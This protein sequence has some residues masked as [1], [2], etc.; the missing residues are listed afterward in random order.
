M[1]RFEW[2]RQHLERAGAQADLAV[3][4]HRAH[5]DHPRTGVRIADH[6][7]D[8]LAQLVAGERSKPIQERDRVHLGADGA[9]TYALDYVDR[10][11]KD[12]WK[13]ARIYGRGLLTP[14]DVHLRAAAGAWPRA[15]CERVDDRPAPI[16]ASASTISAP[17]NGASWLPGRPAQLRRASR[18]FL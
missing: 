2:I 6:S 3:L 5:T 13:F 18:F 12:C 11:I 7:L 1:D 15:V 4:A 10:Y 14:A 9:G 8:E 17:W 16:G